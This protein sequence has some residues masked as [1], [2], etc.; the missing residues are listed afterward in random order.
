MSMVD[1]IHSVYFLVWYAHVV[2]SDVYL[3]AQLTELSN[4]NE[5]RKQLSKFQIKFYMVVKV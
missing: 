4:Q 3:I 5:I 2:Y 1:V